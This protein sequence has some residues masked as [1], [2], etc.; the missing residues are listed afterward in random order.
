[1]RKQK[2]RVPGST[3]N[4]GPGFDTLG[5]AVNLYLHLEARVSKKFSIEFTGEGSG[6]VS[7]GANN[8][9]Y[10]SYKKYFQKVKEP[11]VPIELFVNNEIPLERGLGSSAAA[12]VGGLQLAAKFA[13]RKLTKEELLDLA[14]SIEGH[15][16]NV[17]PSLFGGMTACCSIKNKVIVSKINIPKVIKF[18]AVIPDLTTSTQQARNI[19]PSYISFQNAVFNVQRVSLLVNSFNT[20]DLSNMHLCFSDKLHQDYRKKFVP[21]FDEVVRRGLD[22]GALGVYLSGSGPTVMAVCRNKGALVVR[23]MVKVFI[24]KRITYTVRYLEPVLKV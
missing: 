14:S 20:G 24:K 5:M 2:I 12:I 1:M 13:K 19:L 3:S 9:I 17:A 10:K 8:L 4:L 16:D 15:P 23:E 11:V 18:A 7:E 21:G 6:Q 22:A